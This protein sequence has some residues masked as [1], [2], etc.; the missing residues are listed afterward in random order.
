MVDNMPVESNDYTGPDRRSNKVWDRRIPNMPLGFGYFLRF[1][2]RTKKRFWTLFILACI[3]WIYVISQISI[4]I[5]L[6]Y[7]HTCI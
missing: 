5:Y 6:R 1:M 4:C 3:G 7:F 2:Y